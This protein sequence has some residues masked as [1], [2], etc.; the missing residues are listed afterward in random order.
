MIDIVAL[1]GFLSLGAI[2]AAV[3]PEILIVIVVVL[4]CF[5]L[6][7]LHFLGILRVGGLGVGGRQ[8]V[9]LVGCCGQRR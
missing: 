3:L 6:D 8:A 4:C 9:E 5:L 7:C 2:A 1:L